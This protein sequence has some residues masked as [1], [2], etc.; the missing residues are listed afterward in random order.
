MTGEA[1]I[2]VQAVDYVQRLEELAG[3]VGRIAEVVVERDASEQVVARH[4][5][6]PVRLVE[7][8]VRR[9]MPG[10]LVDLPAAEVGVDLDAW[11]QVAIG[12]D[13]PV[14]PDR[15]AA[16]H[17][18]RAGDQRIRYPALASHLDTPLE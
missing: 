15:L 6:L 11:Q 10:R 17:L 13:E 14:N 2:A 16:P 4:Q 5:Q 7:A 12:C 9:S 3:G 1:E 8:D 18:I